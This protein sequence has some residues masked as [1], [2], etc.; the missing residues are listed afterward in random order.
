M[1]FFAS[2]PRGVVLVDIGSAT[3]G[4]SFMHLEKGKSPVLCYTTRADVIPREGEDTTTATLRTLEEVCDLLTRE[5]AAALYREIGTATLDM[6]LASVSAPWQE[7]TVKTVSLHEEHSFVFTRAL[8]EK[9]VKAEPPAP[10]RII[11]DTSVIATAL[12]GYDT[13]KPW[14]K[15]ADRADITVLTSTLDKALAKGVQQLL[16]KAF[17]SHRIEITAFAPVSFAVISNLYPLQKDFVLIDVGGTATDAMIVKKGVIAGVRSLPCGVHD[18]LLAGRKASGEVRGT[19]VIDPARNASFGPRVAAAEA[20]WLSDMKAVLAD[21]ASEHPLPRS[22]FLLADEGARDFLK[23]LI[24]ESAL[25][26]LWLSEEPLSVIPLAP[27][28]TANFVRARGMADG[29]IFLSML[30]LFYADR[31]QA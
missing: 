15:R 14:G 13:D 6:V 29:D 9:A 17:H 28:H 21:F 22:V 2:K 10:T 25:R 11:S 23:R 4:G 20:A 3:V 16:R 24:D 27:E 5:G 19:S 30:A 26:T 8:M 1:G 31:L 7:T 18:L 12:N